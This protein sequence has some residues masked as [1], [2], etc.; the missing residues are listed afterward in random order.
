M[1]K[2]SKVYALIIDTNQRILVGK[3]AIGGS[4]DDTIHLP[5]GTVDD[6][7]TELSHQIAALKK[8]LGEELGTLRT[9]SLLKLCPS[10]ETV[11]KIQLVEGTKEAGNLVHVEIFVLRIST[12]QMN[13]LVGNGIITDSKSSKHDRGFSQCLTRN[14]GVAQKKFTTQGNDWFAHACKNCPGI[15]NPEPIKKDV[16]EWKSAPTRSSVRASTKPATTSR[17]KQA[18]ASSSTSNGFGALASLMGSDDD[19]SE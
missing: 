12:D 15:I 4:T 6:D 9:A 1:P 10:F 19:E 2:S 5:G 16:D 14:L 3:Q 18:V 17:A 13:E 8:E 7:S 11:D